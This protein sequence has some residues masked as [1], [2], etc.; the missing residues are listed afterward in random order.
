MLLFTVNCKHHYTQLCF[1]VVLNKSKPVV[2]YYVGEITGVKYFIVGKQGVINDG[3]CTDNRI[4]HLNGLTQ[5]VEA[6]VLFIMLQ[7]AV[8]A[9]V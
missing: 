2:C 4:N 8:I 3:Y 5:T 1:W 7:N 9:L 6:R